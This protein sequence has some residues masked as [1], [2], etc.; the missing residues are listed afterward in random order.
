LVLQVISA[1]RVVETCFSFTKLWEA[2][3]VR[4]GGPCGFV[5]EDATYGMRRTMAEDGLFRDRKNAFTLA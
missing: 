1:K 2:D 3:L 5:T 4:R